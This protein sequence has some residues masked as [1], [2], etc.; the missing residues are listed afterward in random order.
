MGSEEAS[1]MGIFDI[2][3]WMSVAIKAN[4]IVVGTL[5]IGLILIHIPMAH[6]ARLIIAFMEQIFAT[7]RLWSPV[8]TYILSPICRTVFKESILLLFG[9]IYP[10]LIMNLIFHLQWTLDS[11][12]RV[13]FS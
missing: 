10:S 5:L 9:F 6:I 3:W 7:L 1:D 4:N 2:I 8:E 13:T 12:L 11:F